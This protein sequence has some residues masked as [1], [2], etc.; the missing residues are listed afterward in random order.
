M[1]HARVTANHRGDIVLATE[2]ATPIGIEEPDPFTAHETDG[3]VVEEFA[4][5]SQRPASPLLKFTFVR[6]HTS[7]SVG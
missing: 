5:R 7:D 4:N 2:E 1:P 6:G 3:L